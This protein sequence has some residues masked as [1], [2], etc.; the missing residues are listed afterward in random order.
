MIHGYF[1]V[2]SCSLCVLT[3]KWLFQLLFERSK[4]PVM[5]AIKKYLSHFE[6]YVSIYF[7]RD[8]SSKMSC[9]RAVKAAWR[10]E[11]KYSPKVC[12]CQLA[13]MIRIYICLHS[14]LKITS[15]DV[16]QDGVNPYVT[17]TTRCSFCTVLL[18][19]N[20][21]TF[22]MWWGTVKQQVGKVN[23][24]FIGPCIILIVE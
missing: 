15:N 1:S 3:W 11:E 22:Q 21:P 8:A 24:M 10:P 2:C 20:F 7:A 16:T 18:T 9:R 5:R 12:V 23:L 6:S 13:C 17:G 4:K 19:L 14:W